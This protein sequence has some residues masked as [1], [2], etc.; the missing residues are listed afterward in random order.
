M[1]SIDIREAFRIFIAAIGNNFLNRSENCRGILP[2]FR[3]DRFWGGNIGP[4]IP[5]WWYLTTPIGHV[6]CISIFD[7]TESTA[8]VM[9]A[10]KR[11]KII[12]VASSKGV[13]WSF[14]Y[15]LKAILAFSMLKSLFQSPVNSWSRYISRTD[16]AQNIG[17]RTLPPI[18]SVPDSLIV[19]HVQLVIRFFHLS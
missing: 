2:R 11:N 8:S 17:K 7:L 4:F 15:I 16:I 3:E 14:Q 1:R 6:L 13:Q 12:M 5:H 10:S 18:N 19:H 9:T